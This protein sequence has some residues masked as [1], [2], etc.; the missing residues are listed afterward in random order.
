MDVLLLITFLSFLISFFFIYL[1][2]AKKASSFYF[3]FFLFWDFTFTCGYLATCKEGMVNDFIRDA[4]AL[5]FFVFLIAIPP[6]LFTIV[7]GT[8]TAITFVKIEKHAYLPLLLFGINVFSL[9]YLFLGGD[10]K[11]FTGELI[12][13][14]ITYVNY[15]ALLFLFPLS[16]FYYT[17]RCI[18]SIRNFSNEQSLPFYKSSQF[19]VVL[20]YVLF[21]IFLFLDQ[22]KLFSSAVHLSFSVYASFYLSG[23][24]FLFYRLLLKE[25]K[26]VLQG[27]LETEAFASDD[28][29]LLSMETMEMINTNLMRFLQETKRYLDPNIKINTIAKEIGTNSKYLSH[30]I[31][32]RYNKSY[33]AFINDF[34]IEHAKLLLGDKENELFTIETIAKMS[35]FN[36]KSLFNAEFKKLT[37][38]TPSDFKNQKGVL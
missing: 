2:F 32:F 9:G 3:L 12:E 18:Q 28:Q 37:G 33:S 6:T 29:N 4:S 26:I 13:N 30:L 31:N 38:F 16:N 7:K 8:Y 11:N 35:G 27:E 34:R 21:V 25:R 20:L 14:V 19:Q 17:Y 10:A 5:L 23:T 1:V 36:S 24:A 22:I 15:I